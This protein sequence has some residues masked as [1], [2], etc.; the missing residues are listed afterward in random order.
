M[1]QGI[2]SS[3]V[4]DFIRS[5][6]G[7]V[8]ALALKGSPFK[9]IPTADL[10]QQIEGHRKSKLK[11]PTWHEKLGI[12]YPPKINLEQTSSE[13]TAKH[14]A[15][16]V[17]GDT[18]ADLT[19][20]YGV[21]GYFFSQKF[22][23]VDHFEQSEILSKIS[24]YNYEKMEVKNIRCHIGDSLE[25]IQNSKYDVIYVDPARRHSSKGKVFFL[26]DCEPDIVSNFDYIMDRCETLLLKTSPMLD[27]SIGLSELKNVTAIHIVAIDNEV[28][29]LL[30]VC[31]EVATT[32]SPNVFTVNFNKSK[33]EEFS[34]KYGC[35]SVASYHAP[36]QFLYEPNT[37]ILK[38][39]AF[40]VLCDRFGVHKLHKSSHL[41]T[42]DEIQEFPGRSFKI[43]KVIPY[44]KKT[45]R[46]EFAGVKAN[47]TV[48][49]FP[50]SVEQLRKKWSLKDGGDRYLFFTTKE[51][52]HK[53]VIDCSKV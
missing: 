20:G 50:E 37:A 14:K 3:T 15:Q 8:T 53:V 48:R 6:K 1:L 34:F 49:N 41:Y 26:K 10:I 46:T 28:K 22:K 36:M 31:Q 2:V 9:D 7:D 12:I 4:Q 33:K 44:A 27:I 16:L 42:S 43:N 32:E 19:G 40:T 35:S 45:M 39:G 13:I 47:V 29:E 52:D 11:L 25:G 38:S 24:A 21:D 30:W 17:K 23:S 51:S 18:L 5:Y